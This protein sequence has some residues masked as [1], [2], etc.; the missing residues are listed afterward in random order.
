MNSKIIKYSIYFFDFIYYSY[1][2]TVE[3]FVINYIYFVKYI[4]TW[5]YIDVTKK[6]YNIK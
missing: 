4:V 3:L 6:R 2:I 5:L 1:H